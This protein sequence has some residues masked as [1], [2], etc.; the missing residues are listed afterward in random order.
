MTVTKSDRYQ[1]ILGKNQNAKDIKQQK[2]NPRIQ[3]VE[4]KNSFL[5][6]VLGEGREQTSKKYTNEDGTPKIT[7]WYP[8]TVIET[9]A[10]VYDGEDE[11]E[12][13]KGAVV[14]LKGNAGLK[15]QLSQVPV[16]HAVLIKYVGKDGQAY[17]FEV[18]DL[19]E[20]IP[21]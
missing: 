11:I 16:G 4:V 15:N 1:E 9:D 5:H 18:K 6:A 13:V 10:P 17:K 21:F 19:G 12:V 7:T 3:L 20:N 2:F 14:D 8:M